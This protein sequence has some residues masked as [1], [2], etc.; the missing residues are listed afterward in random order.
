LLYHLFAAGVGIIALLGL[1][2]GV[3]ALARRQTGECDG[4]DR[5]A[6]DACAPERAGHCSMRLIESDTE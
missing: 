1:W 4:P 2:L 3:Q 5:V 6:C